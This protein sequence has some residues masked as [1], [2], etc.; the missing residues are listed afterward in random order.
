MHA[1]SIWVG[2]LDWWTLPWWPQ[3]IFVRLHKA[4]NQLF[5]LLSGWRDIRFTALCM[6]TPFCSFASQLHHLCRIASTEKWSPSVWLIKKT[7]SSNLV[8]GSLLYNY[9]AAGISQLPHFFR[10][11][12]R[13]RAAEKDLKHVVSASLRYCPTTVSFSMRLQDCACLRENWILRFCF[14]WLILGWTQNELTQHG[15]V[16]S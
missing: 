8:P 6:M 9:S 10:I 16:V 2:W 5:P 1:G 12:Q 11:I 7:P 4:G 15:T 14:L 13:S 3:F